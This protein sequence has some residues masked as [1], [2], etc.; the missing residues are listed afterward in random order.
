MAEL[1]HERTLGQL[2]SDLMNEIRTLLQQEVRL[3]KTELTENVSRLGK[4]I[5]S[6]AVGG[7]VAYAGVLALVAAAV[8]GL[9]HI[10]PYWLAALIVGLV[11]T[12]IGAGLIQQGRKNLTIDKLSPRKTVESLQEDKQWVKEQIK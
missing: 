12:G 2:F 11:I 9:A 1:K 7:A 5:A 10:V 8:I 4:N 6:L 3:A